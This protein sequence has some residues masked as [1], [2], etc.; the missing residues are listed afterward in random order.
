MLGIGLKIL[1]DN[2]PVPYPLI[3]I[4]AAKSDPW[5]VDQEKGWIPKA[6]LNKDKK[7]RKEKPPIRPL[8]HLR[9]RDQTRATAI[10]LCLADAVESAQ[11][12]CSESNFLNAQQNKVYSYGNRLYCNWDGTNAWFRW[13]NSSTYRKFFTDYQ[14]FLKRPVSI[15]RMVANNQHDIDHVFIVNL[16]LTKF[17]DHIDRLIL[18]AVAVS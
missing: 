1:K 9:V 11:G 16:D 4:P 7:S 15:G 18:G 13:G 2:D 6:L 3:L 12:D 8:S 10:M 14:N 17:Y 5:I